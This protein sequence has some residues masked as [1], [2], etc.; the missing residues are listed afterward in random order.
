MKKR[1]LALFILI[2]LLYLPAAAVS[3]TPENLSIADSDVGFTFVLNKNVPERIWFF[4]PSNPDSEQAEFYF[5]LVSG[6]NFTWEMVV[7]VGWSFNSTDSVDIKAKFYAYPNASYFNEGEGFMLQGDEAKGEDV[8]K[9]NYSVSVSDAA[10]SGFTPLITMTGGDISSA[11]LSLSH[12]ETIIKRVETKG[13]IQGKAYIKLT[14]NAPSMGDSQ[15]LMAT[16][17]SGYVIVEA[18]VI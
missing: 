12:L 10:D 7:G 8:I 13:A 17:Y 2:L 14:L 18:S 4:S 6:S 1:Y 15:F 3:T 5:P 11:N 9:L 16:V